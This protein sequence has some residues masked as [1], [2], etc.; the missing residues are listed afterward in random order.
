[1]LKSR[2]M[3]KNILIIF[4]F[5]GLMGL[6]TSCEEDGEKIIFPSDVTPPSIVSLPEM[7]L[8][9]ANANDTL[10]FLG[11]AVDPGFTASATYFLEA[12]QSGN[13]FVDIVQVYTGVNADTIEIT[14]SELNSIMIAEFPADATTSVDFR[15][16]AVLLVDAGPLP[17][18]ESRDPMEYFSEIS[19]ADVAIYGLPRLDLLNSGMDQK[20]QSPKGDGVYSGFVN[21]DTGSPFT[22]YDP[23][24]DVT[25]GGA[26]GS[27][28]EGGAAITPEA[29]GWHELEVNLN[30]LTYELNPYSIGVVGEFTGWGGDPDFP[31]DYD[32]E[33]GMWFITIDLPAGPMKFRLNSDWGVNWGPGGDTELPAGGG[34]LTL[35]DSNGNIIITTAGNY[36]IHLT[37][38][39]SSGMVDFI[40]ND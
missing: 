9:R 40:L 20:I 26:A 27:I 11:S 16:R 12:C 22:I 7:T 29:D 3:K 14:V 13:G 31:M 4:A 28:S 38:N 24:N 17:S 36:T 8:E 5:I 21:L 39:G 25:Y 18:G 19:T 35:P 30:D 1:M 33:E 15:L 37:L 2:T 23:D 34:E 10:M 6:F 32:P